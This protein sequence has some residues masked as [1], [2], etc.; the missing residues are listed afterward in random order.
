M[1]HIS[2]CSIV[3]AD[4]CCGAADS[5]LTDYM[6][7]T[8]ACW[9]HRNISKLYTLGISICS[10]ELELSRK[11]QWL[12]CSK[13][14]VLPMAVNV[15]NSPYK[16]H[17]EMSCFQRLDV[18]TAALLNIQVFQ[19]AKFGHRVCSSWCLKDHEGT[20]ILPNVKNCLLNDSVPSQ[21]TSIFE[22]TFWQRNQVTTWLHVTGCLYTPLL[23][24]L[25]IKI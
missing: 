10:S 14:L 3:A 19:D 1:R 11:H 4:K 22:L 5:W 7:P 23:W 25:I 9:S 15:P 18:H 12:L 2:L 16:S 8:D 20:I 13:A 24:L 6:Q 21:K 17:K